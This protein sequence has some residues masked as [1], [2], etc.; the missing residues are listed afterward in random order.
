MKRQTDPALPTP[1][2]GSVPVAIYT[3]VSTLNQVGGRFDSC[4]S[5]AYICREFVRKH[6]NEGW[7]E[8]ACYTDAAYSGGTMDRPG[9]QALRR[10]IEAGKVKIVV[11]FK[12]ER[13]LRNTDEWALF[14]SF[15]R[16]H[17]C[18]LV[19]TT[20]DLTEETP[21][22]RLKNNII[23][24]VSE[25][26]RLNTAEKVKAKLAALTE[27][28]IWNCGL[29]PFGYD[30]DKEKKELH[31]HGSEAEIVRGIF[32]KAAALVSLTAIANGLNDAGLRTR[33]RL[34]KR[35]TGQIDNV[36]G[37]RFRSDLL[38]N[39]VR[40]PI[41]KGQLRFHGKEYPGNHPGLVSADLWQ[42]ANAAVKASLQPARCF[43]RPRNK[44]NHSLKGFVHCA[45]CGMAMTPSIGGKR[46]HD[47][48]PYRY[49]ICVSVLKEG[50]DSPCRVRAVPALPLESAVIQFIGGIGRHPDV[51]AEALRSTKLSARGERAEL[52]ARR[53]DIDAALTAIDERIR[54]C[55]EVV[56]AS[57]AGAL[58]EEL[59]SR[60]ADLREERDRQ[61]VE[62][63]QCRQQLQAF[64]QPELDKQRILDAL[65][66]FERF[67]PKLPPEEQREL[68]SLCV[69]RVD[70]SNKSLVGG[71]ARGLQNLA[72]NVT[73]PVAD[74][75]SG[76]ENGLVVRRKVDEPPVST[77]PVTVPMQLAIRTRA[78]PAQ[79]R[80]TKP[81]AQDVNFDEAVPETGRQ[82][83]P[84]KNETAHPLIRAIAW[85]RKLDRT[86]GLNQLELARQE[87]VTPATLSYH[88]SLLN[89]RPAIQDFIL[90]STN[91][92]ELRL[93]SLRR[94]RSL[95]DLKPEAQLTQFRIL[96]PRFSL[97]SASVRTEVSSQGI[98]NGPSLSRPPNHGQAA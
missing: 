42:R 72:V 5:Q 59:R 88:M 78:Y 82:A 22:G 13:I 41:Y 83:G 10:E 80:I 67:F 8:A 61:L 76:I 85:K 55:L 70:V 66:R 98:S 27:R 53:K 28:G 89:L 35:R 63:E 96:C 40:N 65:G 56:A 94:L 58:S 81:F 75:V 37:K 12:L 97:R 18:R 52:V 32:E 73:V 62:R 79:A 71:Q 48:A 9:I 39:L 31:P 49:Y 20:E 3:R 90:E 29:V 68:L 91:R 11:I 19:S 7:Y 25:Y 60:V 6:G 21:S 4:E 87:G 74:L 44:H 14:R 95:A 92:D 43:L 36:G 33:D 77:R 93:C 30:Y 23:V 2:V 84:E 57:G 1:V 38:R 50:K 26:E 45:Q 64:Q 34:F 51:L 69:R 46:D 15:L 17:G 47:G 54:N 86:P 16:R 24:S